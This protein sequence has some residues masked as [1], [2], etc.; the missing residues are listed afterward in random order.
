MRAFTDREKA[1]ASTRDGDVVIKHQADLVVGPGL[2]QQVDFVV[3]TDADGQDAFAVAIGAIAAAFVA[4]DGGPQPR[5]VENGLNGAILS[6]AKRVIQDDKCQKRRAAL[7]SEN[8]T[9]TPLLKG[10]E[11][12]YSAMLGRC[13]LMGSSIRWSC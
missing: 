4:F 1:S 6:T 9:R 10:R 7:T 11:Y 13:I 5:Q 12:L 2:A 8:S 3:V